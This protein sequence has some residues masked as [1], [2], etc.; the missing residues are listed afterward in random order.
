MC[1]NIILK[2]GEMDIDAKIGLAF[3]LLTTVIVVVAFI[4]MG[5]AIW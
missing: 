4:L 2:E 5:L 3:G 1:Q